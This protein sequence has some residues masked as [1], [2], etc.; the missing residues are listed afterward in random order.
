MDIEERAVEGV[1][2]DLDTRKV[3]RGAAIA[4]QR[5][6]YAIEQ[7]RLACSNVN[8]TRGIG[9]GRAFLTCVERQGG[10]KA[11]VNVHQGGVRACQAKRQLEGL[12]GE[13]CRREKPEQTHAVEII[14]LT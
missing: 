2:D 3:E 13:V 11:S 14:A 10:V 1:R 9:D 4:S 7:L 8:S 12:D 5:E 6:G